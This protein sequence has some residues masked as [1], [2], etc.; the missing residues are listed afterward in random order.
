MVS[1]PEVGGVVKRTRAGQVSRRR[2]RVGVE[3][4]MRTDAPRFGSS[5]Q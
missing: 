3:S 1:F 2:L 4:S 5:E